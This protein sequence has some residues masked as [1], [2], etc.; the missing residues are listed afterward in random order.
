M[1]LHLPSAAQ[2]TPPGFRWSSSRS[3]PHPP[4]SAEG[5]PGC[6]R[7]SVLILHGLEVQ[8]SWNNPFLL[9]STSLQSGISVIPHFKC[10][11]GFVRHFWTK[12][13]SDWEMECTVLPP[14]PKR[15][16]VLLLAWKKQIS[17]VELHPF[18]LKNSSLVSPML[19]AA[20]RLQSQL[21]PWG[22]EGEQ[23]K[24]LCDSGQSFLLKILSGALSYNALCIDLQSSKILQIFFLLF[25][26]LLL[27]A[28]FIS[29]KG[30]R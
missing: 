14:L 25:G 5:F 20:F 3:F 21:L 29:I 9:C 7:C 2:K 18:I 11:F 23:R 17:F 24:Q 12:I 8:A 10:L 6:K 26:F 4:T 16:S 15:W 19:N 1:L 22:E 30:L 13:N 28:A 27:I